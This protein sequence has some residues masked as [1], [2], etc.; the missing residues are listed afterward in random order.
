MKKINGEANVLAVAAAKEFGE[1]FARFHFFVNHDIYE[2]VILSYFKTLYLITP[3][4]LPL[5]SLRLRNYSTK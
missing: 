3:I 2:N 4:P 5:T 1:G